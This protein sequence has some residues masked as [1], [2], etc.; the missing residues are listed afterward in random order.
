MAVDF[1]ENSFRKIF[2]QKPEFQSHI[3]METPTSL[4]DEIHQSGVSSCHP[5]PLRSKSLTTSMT[6]EDADFSDV[7]GFAAGYF[8]LIA[9]AQ[10]IIYKRSGRTA[11]GAEIARM[12]PDELVDHAM[13]RYRQAPGVS[14]QG[15]SIYD[16]LCAYMDDH[17]HTIQ[18]SPKQRVRASLLE[19]Q[20]GDKIP[21]IEDFLDE[22]TAPPSREIESE[23]EQKANRELIDDIK[24]AFSR[25]SIE[26]RIIDAWLDGITK[27][28]DAIAHLKVKDREYDSATRRMERAAWKAKT[29]FAQRTRI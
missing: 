16:Q 2:R 6:F 21:S 5:P 18:K 26:H 13:T 8:R 29:A 4:D 23:E 15:R 28:S 27:R 1:A 7:G 24:S 12:A 11:G 17:A 25:G 19:F 14:V 10:K 22:K 3:D 20:K 9:Q